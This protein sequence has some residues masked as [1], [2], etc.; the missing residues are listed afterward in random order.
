[1][2]RIFLEHIGDGS[3]SH[4]FC[5]SMMNLPAFRFFSNSLTDVT[6]RK[7]DALSSDAGCA[8]C[9]TVVTHRNELFSP[10]DT[11]SLG[12]AFLFDTAVNL[13]YG[14]VFDGT[15]S[16]KVREVS[17]KK[18]SSR[19]GWFYEFVSDDSERYKEG[20]VLL[21]RNLVVQSYQ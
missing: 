18:C 14:K 16:E 5:E 4:L 7:I 6:V 13:C 11:S 9:S 3:P 1:M 19:L 2:G 8:K 10:C 20:R 17:C 21:E 12:S 15:C